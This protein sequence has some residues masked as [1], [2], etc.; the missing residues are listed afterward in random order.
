MKAVILDDERRGRELLQSLIKLYC[1]E[2]QVMALCENLVEAEAAVIA[3]KPDILFLDIR[4]G[5]DM[6]FDLLAFL[7]QP[8]PAV[9]VTTAHEEYAIKAIKANAIDYLLKPIVSD[10][11]KAAVQKVRGQRSVGNSINTVSDVAPL[12]KEYLPVPTNEGINFVKISDI[13]RLEASGAYTTIFLSQGKLLTSTNLGEFEKQLNENRGFF[14]IHHSYLINLVH[15]VR[16][17]KNDGG[18][19]VLSDQ[20]QVPVSQRKKSL[21]LEIVKI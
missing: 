2:L 19:V 14:R 6:G 16:F 10:E 13:V 21:F 3:H 7:P 8:Q 15:L 9:I 18:Y 20:S 12:G 5:A 1:P 11:L 4:V 17:V